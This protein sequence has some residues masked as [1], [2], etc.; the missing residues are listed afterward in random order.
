MLGPET[1][2]RRPGNAEDN[3]S[4]PQILG[5]FSAEQAQWGL[6]WGEMGENNLGDFFQNVFW[7]LWGF[8]YFKMANEGPRTY[9]S[10]F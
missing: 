6:Q 10:I 2:D 7:V 8:N 9:C 4:H 1:G 5:A 3:T